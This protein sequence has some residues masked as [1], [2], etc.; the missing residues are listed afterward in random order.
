MPN[1]ARGS[2]SRGWPTDPTLTRYLIPAHDPDVASSGPSGTNPSKSAGVTSKD[3]R[4]VRVAEQAQRPARRIERAAGVVGVEDVVVLVE[5]RAVADLDRVVDR[6]GPLRQRAQVL[7]VLGRERLEGPLRR[8]PRDVVERA[9]VVD[10]AR[11]LVVI[12]A[13]DRERI[14]RAHAI[15]DRVRLGAV[16][17]QI[18]EHERAIPACL[19]APRRAPRRARRCSR[20]CRRGSGTARQIRPS[21]D[22]FEDALGDSLRG[23]R[24]AASIAQSA[25]WRTRPG[26]ARTAAPSGRDRRPADAGRRPAAGATS[27]S[28][29]TSSQTDTPSMLMAARLSGSMNVPPPVA[30]TTWRSGSRSR[31]MSRSSG[32]EVRLATAR[33]DVGDGPPLA[34]FDQLVDVL[35]APAEPRGERA[36]D[37]RLAGRHESDEINLVGRHRVSRASSSK[38]PGIR[39]VDRRRAADRRRAGARVAAIANAIASR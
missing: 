2:P 29:G 19:Q 4:E 35:G 21:A 34:C 18:A 30:T 7:A 20:E 13:N 37:G 22:R 16:A 39:D 9:A 25:R 38:K 12:A 8:E 27:S 26:A 11:G 10:P 32:A 5:R 33:E 14:Q 31:R 15:D 28:S 3:D 24:R 23:A 1:A 17:D 6:H 36:R